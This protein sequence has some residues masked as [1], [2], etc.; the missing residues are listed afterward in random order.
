MTGQNRHFDEGRQT[1]VDAVAQFVALIHAR[2][3]G[4]QQEET[5]ALHRLAQLG[6]EVLFHQSNAR[7]KGGECG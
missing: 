4:K 1:S 2:E 3:S 7:Q 6:V 5:E